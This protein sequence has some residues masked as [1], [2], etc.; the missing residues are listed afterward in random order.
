MKEE[1]I[2]VVILENGKS[3]R[4]VNKVT[5]P[6]FKLAEHFGLNDHELMDWQ[7]SYEEAES[8]L[9]TFWIEPCEHCG[10]DGI[11]IDIDSKRLECPACFPC[12]VGSVHQAVVVND[13]QV[14]IL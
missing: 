4:E 12:L 7:G 13:K 11:Y 3:C 10:G 1:I 6:T 9:R 5:F 2:T 8:K 14:R